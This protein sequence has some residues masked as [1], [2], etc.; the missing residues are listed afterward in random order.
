MLCYRGKLRHREMNSAPE[1]Q[2]K[3]RAGLGTEPQPP[4]FLSRALLRLWVL[5]GFCLAL[6]AQEAVSLQT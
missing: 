4:E 2:Q 3:A 5:P 6:S 1:G